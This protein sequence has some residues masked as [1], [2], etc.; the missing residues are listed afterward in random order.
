[1]HLSRHRF[2]GLLFAALLGSAGV[3]AQSLHATQELVRSNG[4]EPESLD[5][6][7]AETVN[8]AQIVNDLFEGLTALDRDGR[9]VPGVAES[10]KQTN[11]TTWVFHLRRNAKFSNGDPLTAADFVYAWRR[12]LDPKTASTYA[13]TY[14]VFLQNG[15][16]IAAGKKPPS[17]LGV[18]ALDPYTLE[19]H[20][21][22]PVP[23]MLGL[24][25]NNQLAPVS[26]AAVEKWGRDWIRAGTMVSNGPYLLKEAI[27]NSRI[28][29]VPNPSYWNQQAV[30]LTRVTYLPI[31]DANADVQLYQSG[32]TDMVYQLPPGTFAHYQQAYPKEI[33]NTALLAIRYISLNNQDPVLK[34]VRVRQALS[35]VLDRDVLAQKVTAD[36][37]VPLYGLIAPGTEGASASAY[38]WAQWPMAQKVR[39]AQKLLAQAG[40]PAGTHIRYKYNTSDYHKKMAIF[41]AAEWKAK[42]GLDVELENLE[43][44]VWV[45]QLHDRDY[46]VGRYGWTVDY[47]DATS[48]LSI[49]QC[50]SEQNVSGSCNHA[51]DALGD[52]GNAQSDPARRAALL[53]QAANLVM[54]DYPFIPLLQRTQP[55][56]VKTYVGGYSDKNAMDRIRSIDL[57]ILK[58]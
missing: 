53:T 5:P 56:L 42:L 10:W 57:Y 51:S 23:F 47:N 3:Q 8:S 45:K 41:T 7:L 9:T 26:R 11:P 34:D 38:A 16:E 27:V 21:S 14:G 43:A 32:E 58:H 54:E 29:L 22:V 49:V 20:T 39:A 28:V 33:H 37:Q 30:H 52:Q 50:N 24:V 31:E 18:R 36:G 4:G 35:M 25:A 44:K 6:A 40:V 19:V 13:N 1:M 2:A 17:A 12:F 46:Q 15:A 55:R 48:F